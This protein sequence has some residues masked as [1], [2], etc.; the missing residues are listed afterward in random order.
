MFDQTDSLC[1]SFL[2]KLVCFSSVLD[3]G[4]LYSRELF[5]SYASDSLSEYKQLVA[6]LD[7]VCTVEYAHSEGKLAQDDKRYSVLFCFGFRYYA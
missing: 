5:A 2:P 3:A 1:I 7:K 6:R 4:W